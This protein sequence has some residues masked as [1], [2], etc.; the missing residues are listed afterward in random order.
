MKQWLVIARSGRIV[1][2]APVA[3]AYEGWN[4]NSLY[5]GKPLLHNGSKP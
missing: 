1:L 5:V 4:K 2:T 3:T